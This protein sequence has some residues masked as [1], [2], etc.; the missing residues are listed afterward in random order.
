MK[1][2]FIL[3]SIV[4]LTAGTVYAG[5]GIPPPPGSVGDFAGHILQKEQAAKGQVHTPRYTKCNGSGKIIKTKIVWS[6][7]K[8]KL[9]K[10]RQA[11]TCPKCSGKGQVSN[12]L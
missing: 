7:L 8:K 5:M 11:N 10:A 1:K 9:V 12:F 2:F 4:L 6:K 3:W